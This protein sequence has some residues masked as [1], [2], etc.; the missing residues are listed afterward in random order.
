VVLRKK[1][2]TFEDVAVENIGTKLGG[3]L[4]TL[5]KEK[6]R[7]AG[8]EGGVLVK[9]ITAG[10]ALSRTRMNEGFVITTVNGEDVTTVEALAKI[11]ANAN[12]SVRIEGVYPG[13]DGSYVY[14]L[15]LQQ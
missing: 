7:E 11:L 14:P 13:Y 2:G 5:D 3:E 12:G 6:A 10:G 9:K 15:N 1:A 8:I 4:V